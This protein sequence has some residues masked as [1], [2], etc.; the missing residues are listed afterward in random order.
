MPECCRAEERARTNGMAIGIIEEVPQPRK[1]RFTDFERALE[2]YRPSSVHANE[3]K[4]QQAHAGQVSHDLIL[5]PLLLR[6]L[7]FRN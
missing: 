4:Q 5:H 2:T 3:Y 7:G 1:L 6:V